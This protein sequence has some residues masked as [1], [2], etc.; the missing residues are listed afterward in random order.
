M[1]GLGRLLSSVSVYSMILQALFHNIVFVLQ[2][3]SAK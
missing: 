1:I 2:L 3:L